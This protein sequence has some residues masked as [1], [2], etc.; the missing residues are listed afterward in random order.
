M[1]DSFSHILL[2]AFSSA[3]PSSDTACGRLIVETSS[4]PSPA[5][6]AP[7][8]PPGLDEADPGKGVVPSSLKAPCWYMSI[9]KHA[10]MRMSVLRSQRHNSACWNILGSCAKRRSGSAASTT[11]VNSRSMAAKRSGYHS[12]S[13]H[14]SVVVASLCELRLFVPLPR[15]TKHTTP[16]NKRKV[17]SVATTRLP[18]VIVFCSVYHTPWADIQRSSTPL[19]EL[20]QSRKRRHWQNRRQLLEN[21][22]VSYW[23]HTRCVQ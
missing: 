17:Q 3:A 15:P 4:P 6:L 23:N 5:L 22:A 8:S 21:M 9:R 16:D 14:E 10:D 20:S 7:Q 11:V 19:Q 2:A 1:L 18:L 12:S 13:M